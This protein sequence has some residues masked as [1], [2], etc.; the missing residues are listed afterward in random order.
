M[1]WIFFPN[2]FRH[3]IFFNLGVIPIHY[4]NLLCTL[5]WPHKDERIRLMRM[6]NFQLLM[7]CGN[8][9]FLSFWV[10]MDSLAP[11]SRHLNR[12]DKWQLPR[13]LR[14]GH[15][16]PEGFPSVCWDIGSSPWPCW[17]VSMELSQADDCVALGPD[18]VN[19]ENLSLW[20]DP[21]Y[22]VDFEDVAS[23]TVNPTAILNFNI[24]LLGSED[25]LSNSGLITHG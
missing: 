20:G 10:S 21:N 22:I 18:T 13:D 19:E 11:R 15:L 25:M 4:Y 16:G 6:W 7:R 17:M 24:C 1:T 9:S 8:N 3:T 14:G 23:I 12:T 2:S 5:S